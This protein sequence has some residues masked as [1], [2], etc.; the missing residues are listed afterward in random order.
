MLDYNETIATQ[1]FSVEHANNAKI[2]EQPISN[3][4]FF[5]LIYVI[6]FVDSGCCMVHVDYN[7]GNQNATTDMKLTLWTTTIRS[8]THKKEK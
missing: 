6:N 1:S 4:C 7:I 2:E 5:K 8:R 3:Y